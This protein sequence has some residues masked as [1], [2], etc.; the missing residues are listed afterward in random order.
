M[1]YFKVIEKSLRIRACFKTEILT[2]DN[3]YF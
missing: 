1:L 3:M 2:N